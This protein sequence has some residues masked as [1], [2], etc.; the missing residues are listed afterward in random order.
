M[1]T[2]LESDHLVIKSDGQQVE[3]ISKD[4]D[5]G[6]YPPCVIVRIGFECLKILAPGGCWTPSSFEGNPEMVITGQLQ[7][8]GYN[9]D[10]YS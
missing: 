2:L 1:Q 5:P 6:H 3:I 7:L 8:S 4:C 9:H 10:I